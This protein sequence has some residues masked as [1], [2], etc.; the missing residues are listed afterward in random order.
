LKLRISYDD[1][2]TAYINGQEVASAMRRGVGLNST[3]NARH[4]DGQAVLF[5]DFDIVAVKDFLRLGA[6]CWRF[7]GYKRH[8][9]QSR[10]PDLVRAERN[11]GGR[12]WATEPSLFHGANTGSGQW[13]RHN[14]PRP[15]HFQRRPLPCP[16]ASRVIVTISLSLPW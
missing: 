13:H 15:S 6:T 7:K 3:A 5:E 2:F 16:A 4:A 11:D 12:G 9:R 10:F 1:G 8:R 14:G